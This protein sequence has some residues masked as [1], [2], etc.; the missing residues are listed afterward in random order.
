MKWYSLFSHT[1]SETESI[2]K[3]VKLA[4][5]FTNNFDYQGDLHPLVAPSVV[6]HSL[7]MRPDC[8]KDDSVIT[9]NGYMRILPADVISSLE[10]RGIKVY[11]IHPAPIGIYPELRGK[12]PQE[13]LYEGIKSGKY[14]IMGVTIHRVD[15]G[16]DTGKIVTVEHRFA[17]RNLTQEQL[18]KALHAMAAAAWHRFFTEELYKYD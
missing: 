17:D 7:L 6:I 10:K 1:G 5:A 15:E 16:L 13:R 4:G 9:L 11:N 2:S 8:I 14:S 18:D 12:D 3:Y